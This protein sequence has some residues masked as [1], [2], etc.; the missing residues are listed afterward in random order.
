M[1]R[2]KRKIRK[3]RGTRTVGGGSAKSR[4][5]TGSYRTN[6]RTFGT[7]YAYV[8]KYEPWRIKIKGFVGLHKKPKAINLGDV[9][10]LSDEREIDVTKFGYGKVLAAGNISKPITIKAACFSQKAKQK[11][12]KAG[13]KAEPIQAVK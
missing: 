12:E 9:E 7:N 10:K 11:I 3:M 13:G 5:G 1:R 6:R 2:F 4:R 8:C